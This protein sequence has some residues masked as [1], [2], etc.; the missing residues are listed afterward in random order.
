MINILNSSVYVCMITIIKT[1]PMSY[2]FWLG[3]SISKSPT[4]IESWNSGKEQIYWLWLKN[5]FGPGSKIYL[6]PD[7][8][9]IW[10]WIKNMIDLGSTFHLVKAQSLVF[11]CL[12]GSILNWCKFDYI[13]WHSFKLIA[14]SWFQVLKK[15]MDIR[16]DFWWGKQGIFNFWRWKYN[17]IVWSS[18]HLKAVWMRLFQS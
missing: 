7:Q 5:T 6:V 14:F 8:K 9:Y 4:K 10:P 12:S 15:K 11:V 13:I 1:N 16:Q 2:D 17:T 18:C 3:S